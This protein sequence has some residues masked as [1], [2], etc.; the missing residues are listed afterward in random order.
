MTKSFEI[1]HENQETPT[2]SPTLLDTL[3]TPS[4]DQAKDAEALAACASAPASAAAL[5]K[6]HP[7][8]AAFLV[9]RGTRLMDELR[10]KTGRKLGIFASRPALGEAAAIGRG[11][12]A[13]RNA[14]GELHKNERTQ[15]G[16]DEKGV[17]ANMLLYRSIVSGPLSTPGSASLT[18]LSADAEMSLRYATLALTKTPEYRLREFLDRSLLPIPEANGNTYKNYA[19][20]DP[21]LVRAADAA[22]VLSR[23]QKAWTEANKDDAFGKQLGGDF[24]LNQ[25]VWTASQAVLDRDSS[26]TPVKK[27]LRKNV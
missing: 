6:D 11:V 18:R 23:T 3:D 19:P 9:L 21:A 26:H 25:S 20:D 24:D 8:Y 7:L 16:T 14:L 2:A 27:H 17:D 13:L 4:P 10:L 1:P 12:K 5:A 15:A 22:N